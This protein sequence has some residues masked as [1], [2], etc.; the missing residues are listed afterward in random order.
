MPTAMPCA[1]FASRFGKR[2]QH[3]RLS[4]TGRRSSAEVD[5]VLVDAVEQQRA[6]S[7]MRASV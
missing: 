4:P 7:V 3:D 6:T 1:P 5:R 2:R